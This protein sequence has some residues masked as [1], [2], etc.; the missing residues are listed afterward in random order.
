MKKLLIALLSTAA[1][2]QAAIIHFDYSNDSK[3]FADAAKNDGIYTGYVTFVEL[4]NGELTLSDALVG[5]LAVIDI[6]SDKFYLTGNAANPGAGSLFSADFNFNLTAANMGTSDGYTL[7]N[8]AFNNS[9]AS[10]ALAEVETA[11]ALAPHATYTFS[12]QGLG[13]N[14][15]LTSVPE[16]AS[17][18]LMG[19]GLLGMAVAAYSRKG[20]K[21]A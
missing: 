2:T 12:S 18:G 9:I 16:P 15:Q 19:M 11:A 21:Q 4:N 1:L 5:K 3:F 6:N 17:M 13:G 8:L 14:G 20:R 7:N 10:V